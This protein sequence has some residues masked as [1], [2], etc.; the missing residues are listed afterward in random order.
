MLTKDWLTDAVLY[1]YALS[2]LF[3]M[4]DAAYGKRNGRRI[5]TGLLVFVWI[6]QTGFL[7]G[8]LVSRLSMPSVTLKEYAFFVSWLLVSFSLVIHRF[9]RA[10]LLVLLVNAVGFAV[11]ALNLLERPQK[12]IALAPGEAAQRL[13]VVH[14]AFITLAFAMLTVAALLGGMYLFLNDRLKK[15]KWGSFMNRMPSL[16]AI[17]RYMFRAGAVGVPLLLLSLSTGAV[18]L[19]VQNRYWELWD[20]KV[21]LSFAAGAVYVVYLIRRL[22]GKDDGSRVLKWNLAGYALLVVDFFANSYSSFHR[23]M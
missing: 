18:T 8:I 19:L 3:F 15:K 12:Q 11:L 13:L 7:L 10:E 22:A 17:D 21:L 16:E 6:L 2:L 9:V 20:E 1:V 23:W 5:G 4:S 14:I